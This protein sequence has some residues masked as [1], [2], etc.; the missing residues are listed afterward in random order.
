MRIRTMIGILGLGGLVGCGGGDVKTGESVQNEAPLGFSV[1]NM[2]RDVDPREDFYHYAAGGWL[3]RTQIPADQSGVGGFSLLANEVDRKLLTIVHEAAQSPDS[4]GPGQLVG[5]FY[6]SAM[7]LDR[8]DALGLEPLE[9]DLMMAADVSAPA[10]RARLVA[11]H[12][13]VFGGSSMINLAVGPDLLQNDINA[14]YL[15]PGTF[16][17]NRN[18]YFDDSAQGIRDLYLGFLAELF[19]LAGDSEVQARAGA[20]TVLDI[21][22]ALANATLTPLQAADPRA[23]YNKID[24]DEVDAALNTIDLEIM[25]RSLGLTP[26]QTLIV[27]EPRAL[28]ALNRMLTQRPASEIATWQRATILRN[29]ADLLSTPYREASE[30]FSR[31]RKGL[32]AS[33]PREREVIGQLRALLAHPLS[34]LYVERYFPA[35]TRVEVEEMVGHI[36]DE[37]RERLATNPWLTERT[38]GEALAKLDAM[39]VDVG[40][41]DD[42]IDYSGVRVARDDYLGNVQRTLEFTIRRNLELLGQPVRRDHFAVPG[43]TTPVDVNAA[44]QGNYNAIEVTAAFVQPPFYNPDLDIAVNYCTIGAAIG[45]EMTHGFDSRGRLFDAA[46]NLRDWWTPADAAEFERRTGQLIDQFNEYEVMPGVVQ[47]GALTISENTADLGGITLAY[48]ALE[49][50]MAKQGRPADIDGLSPEQ[51]CFI[52]WAQLWMSKARPERVRELAKT[53][54]HALSPLRATGPL[55]NLDAF[56]EAF[57]IGADDPMWRA[58]E[59]RTRIW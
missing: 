32:D 14:L 52:G 54:Y 6:N 44:Y 34:Q 36:K 8:L 15:A 43:K 25:M 1:E 41:P 33:L 23:F 40:Y 11:R 21:E 10:T 35:S 31:Q 51:R 26:P 50:A 42:W 13:L 46:G 58:P 53:D 9:Q 16:G 20:R 7:D 12:E 5:D 18:E 17:L 24:F 47:D 55:V 4:E 56:F 30:S 22:T 57:D 37:F 39:Q 59:K 38:R 49:R 29:G 2:D 28:G 27:R 48:N 45:H 19:R 3:E